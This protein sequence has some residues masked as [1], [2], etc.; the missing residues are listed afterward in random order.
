LSRLSRLPPG[1][2][3]RVDISTAERAPDELA[4]RWRELAVAAENPFVLPEWHAAWVAAYPADASFVLVCREP[5]GDIA[6]VV[7][8]VLRRRRLLAAGEQ[9][10]DWFGPACAPQD[11]A[12]VAAAVVDVLGRT[13]QRW[14]VWQLDRCRTDGAWID[15]LRRAAPGSAL[16]LLAH[17]GDDVLVAVDL[18]RDGPDLTTA[19]KRRELERLGRRLRE[20]HDVQLRR[21]TTPAQIERD[22]E[23]LLRLRTARWGVSFD[24]PEE[25]FVRA[26]AGS[27]AQLHLLRL[28]AI[29]VDGEPAGV[30]LGWRLGSR[31]FAY[32][33]AFDRAHERF[34]IGMALLAHAVRTSAEE[35]C[36]RFDML[37][38]DEHF[39]G[40][41]HIS[42][43]T[44]TSYRAVRRRSL[45]RLRAQALA[46]AHSAYRRL[47]EQ[48][49][50]R[51]RRALRI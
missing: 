29:D 4:R 2:G 49:R 22:L 17:R 25:S 51:L 24:A 38:G 39:K 12:R 47:P 46:G 26:L 33:H 14:D 50:E 6:G 36:A 48:Q 44:V 10:A 28:W 20:A 30:L 5:S 45:A 18:E 19:K 21:S 43:S 40:S 13:T 41:F 1:P 8:L 16:K 32:S 3:L 15:G 23:A 31:A 11:E 9:L 37:R 42:P 35:G 27:L 34:G 7:P